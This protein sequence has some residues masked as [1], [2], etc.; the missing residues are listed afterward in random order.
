MESGV[1]SGE[2]CCEWRVVWL[3]ESGVVSGEWCGEWRVV[4]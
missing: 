1:V 3:V 2:W 4:L